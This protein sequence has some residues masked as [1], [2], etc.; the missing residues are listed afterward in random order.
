M[1]QITLSGIVNGMVGTFCFLMVC[2]IISLVWE[3]LMPEE[4][5]V[6]QYGV[7]PFSDKR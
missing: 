7:R 3:K 4:E 1:I 2:L 6:D 5:E